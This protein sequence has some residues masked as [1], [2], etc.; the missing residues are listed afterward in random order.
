[1]ES[2]R[3]GLLAWFIASRPSRPRG[4]VVLAGCSPSQWRVRAG[5]SPASLLGL[6]ATPSA[7]YSV[8]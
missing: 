2:N 5:F 8:V 4:P 3:A 7:C 6:I 1:M